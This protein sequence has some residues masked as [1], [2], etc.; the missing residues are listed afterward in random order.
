MSVAGEKEKPPESASSQNVTDVTRFPIED[1]DSRGKYEMQGGGTVYRVCLLGDMFESYYALYGLIAVMTGMFTTW[2]IRYAASTSTSREESD[3]DE[4]GTDIDNPEKSP[5]KEDRGRTNSNE[6]PDDS[7]IGTTA[8]NPTPTPLQARPES[9]NQPERAKRRLIESDSDSTHS[10]LDDFA[11][12]MDTVEHPDE[13]PDSYRLSDGAGDILRD[14]NMEEREDEQYQDQARDDAFLILDA[15]DGS[16]LLQGN[17]DANTPKHA[18]HW[19]EDVNL[20]E[21]VSFTSEEDSNSDFGLDEALEDAYAKLDMQDKDEASKNIEERTVDESYSHPPVPVSEDVNLSLT[22]EE[23]SSP[24]SSAVL[25]SNDDSQKTPDESEDDGTSVDKDITT[26]QTSVEYVV[27]ESNDVPNAP[28]VKNAIDDDVVEDGSDDTT[29]SSDADTVKDAGVDVKEREHELDWDDRTDIENVGADVIANE[30]WKD[31]RIEVLNVV[32]DRISNE[33]VDDMSYDVDSRN[34]TFH[35]EVAENVSDFVQPVD[36]QEVE[37]VLRDNV[38]IEN[39]VSD[40]EN[41]DANR[42]SVANV[43]AESLANEMVGDILEESV[44]KSRPTVAADDNELPQTGFDK[45]G[46]ENQL[47]SC[48]RVGDIPIPQIRIDSVDD[49]DFVVEVNVG[50]DFTS[51]QRGDENTNTS[52]LPERDGDHKV[53][54][55]DDFA[56]EAYKR[57]DYIPENDENQNQTKTQTQIST[58]MDVT[59]NV[60]NNDESGSDVMHDVEVNTIPDVQIVATVKASNGDSSDVRDLLTKLTGEDVQS[61]DAGDEGD[62]DNDPK[63]DMVEFMATIKRTNIDDYSDD[64]GDSDVNNHQKEAVDEELISS[65]TAR[66]VECSS[67]DSFCSRPQEPGPDLDRSDTRSNVPE[68]TP[69]KVCEDD[70]VASDVRKKVNGHVNLKSLLKSLNGELS[71]DVDLNDSDVGEASPQRKKVITDE[72]VR[73]AIQYLLQRPFLYSYGMY[74]SADDLFYKAIID[75]SNGGRTFALV[76]SLFGK[77]MTPEKKSAVF[78]LVSSKENLN[79]DD[80]LSEV[81]EPIFPEPQDEEESQINFEE[82]FA[83]LERRPTERDD[84]FNIPPKQEV[85]EGYMADAASLEIRPTGRDDQFNMPPKQEVE[86]GYIA[87]ASGGMEESVPVSSQRITEGYP[88]EEDTVPERLGPDTIFDSDDDSSSVSSSD[89]SGTYILDNQV[90]LVEEDEEEDQERTWYKEPSYP[91]DTSHDPANQSREVPGYHSYYQKQLEEEEEVEEEEVEEEPEKPQ[92]SRMFFITS[93]MLAQA[94]EQQNGESSSDNEYERPRRQSDSDSSE[95]YLEEIPPGY[96]PNSGNSSWSQDP[97]TQHQ[98][99]PGD[100][101]TRSYPSEVPTAEYDYDNG[102]RFRPISGG[103]SSVEPTPRYPTSQALKDNQEIKHPSQNGH[104]V[105]SDYDSSSEL[106]EIEKQGQKLFPSSSQHDDN[107]PPQKIEKLQTSDESI[108]YLPARLLPAAEHTV[109]KKMNYPDETAPTRITDLLGNGTLNNGQH[110]PEDFK[111]IP[112]P[113]ITRDMAV[114]EQLQPVFTRPVFHQGLP[115]DEPHAQSYESLES[116]PT[117]HPEPSMVSAEYAKTNGHTEPLSQSDDSMWLHSDYRGYSGSSEDGGVDYDDDT[118]FAS[119]ERM[120]ALVGL[121]SHSPPAA[122][123]VTASIEVYRAEEHMET[124]R[125]LYSYE[126]S[127]GIAGPEGKMVKLQEQSFSF[128][129]HSDIYVESTDSRYDVVISDSVSDS[130]GEQFLK[131]GQ[132]ENHPEQPHEQSQSFASDR[133]SDNAE[134]SLDSPGEGFSMNETVT[135]DFA[136]EQCAPPGQATDYQAED[137]KLDLPFDSAGEE[138]SEREGLQRQVESLSELLSE[139]TLDM[140]RF[141]DDYP[142]LDRIMGNPKEGVAGYEEGQLIGLLETYRQLEEDVLE[143]MNIYKETKTQL[144]ELDQM[145]RA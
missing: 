144:T 86:E 94:S 97:V 138:L 56:K 108:D 83:S 88:E 68:A 13:Y 7:R 52:A 110:L 23:E 112:E 82:L 60:R 50:E 96:G 71:V 120:F 27:V 126:I 33:M 117:R 132:V 101:P 59:V 141:K 122:L 4:F 91:H 24:E 70:L 31:E 9:A 99:L 93:A 76:S 28:V 5:S 30:L 14:Q 17:G 139:R 145:E 29:T 11:D 21:D 87:D 32:A 72:M 8:E 63:L 111:P 131:L 89:T 18:D 66:P 1:E 38:D 73:E 26:V 140:Q 85:K 107:L 19:V 54:N 129:R 65:A 128:E 45:N 53:P 6:G 104:H 12:A 40:G 124:Q 121:R 39:K 135:A 92:A 25:E 90:G 44:I 61:K 57:S 3:V 134:D 103:E 113:T 79:D 22:T 43:I 42:V 77:E 102:M 133:R 127:K 81:D 78:A 34:N 41:Y 105:F 106:L 62:L 64:D 116:Y 143:L 51:P 36:S 2:V 100:D 80:D 74:D 109:T 118:S 125:S 130:A 46:E 67:V 115:E 47:P 123:S 84:Q 137:F 49:D 114:P 75:D 95:D 136:G 35:E 48:R 16:E 55:D 58:D 69:Q 119:G 142:F 20:P 37:C 10:S 15:D 98:Y